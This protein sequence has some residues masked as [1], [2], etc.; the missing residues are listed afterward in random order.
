GLGISRVVASALAR[1]APGLR[2]PRASAPA[3]GT[4]APGAVLP[5]AL[6]VRTWP[7]AWVGGVGRSALAASRPCQ[8]AD[9]GLVQ[10]QPRAALQAARQHHRAIPDADQPAYRMTHRLEHAADLTVAPFGDR[11]PV[12][13]VRT[14]TAPVFNGAEGSHAVIE[15]HAV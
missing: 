13:A 7:A 11:D 2:P 8:C 15:A 10:F 5:T 3:L 14:F 12:P 9:I 6:F 4:V 1:P